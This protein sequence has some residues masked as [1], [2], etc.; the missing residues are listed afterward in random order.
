M[1]RRT[2]IFYLTH[3]HSIHDSTRYLLCTIL[4]FDMSTCA[5]I[6][7]EQRVLHFSASFTSLL[8]HKEGWSGHSACY[9]WHI[10]SFS[11]ANRHH[12]AQLSGN[13]APHIC[14]VVWW[15]MKG[16]LSPSSLPQ[17]GLLNSAEYIING[18]QIYDQLHTCAIP[19]TSSLWGRKAKNWST[20][21]LLHTLL[22]ESRMNYVFQSNYVHQREVERDQLVENI[23]WV[24][25]SLPQECSC[26]E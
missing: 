23:L 4:L 9:R 26:H 14:C 25:T 2:F 16:F 10:T 12:S 19:K 7:Q 6:L 1:W 5:S 24:R 13:T 22:E 3:A 20:E 17:S 21:F 18:L 8:D 15:L 11:N